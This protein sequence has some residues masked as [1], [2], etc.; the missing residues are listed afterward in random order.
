MR[1]W[2]RIVVNRAANSVVDR[3][4]EEQAFYDRHGRPTLDALKILMA[5]PLSLAE[6]V[7]APGGVANF[8]DC[9]SRPRT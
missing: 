9:E 7:G 8:T 1:Y 2:K 6:F 5:V 4:R 3:A